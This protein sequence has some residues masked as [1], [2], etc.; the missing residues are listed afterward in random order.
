MPINY[1]DLICTSIGELRIEDMALKALNAPTS[2]V[3]LRLDYL[4][5]LEVDKISQ[6]VREAENN[7]KHVIV[8]LRDAGEGGRYV[9]SEDFKANLLEELMKSATPSYVDVEGSFPKSHMLRVK[10]EKL[11]VRTIISYH[12]Y[13]ETPDY[14]KLSSI[15]RENIAKKYDIVKVVTSAKRVEDNLTTLK[16]CYQFKGKTISFCMGRLGRISRLLAPFFGAPFTYAVGWDSEVLA[17][18]QLRV[19]EVVRVWE[20]LGLM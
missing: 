19:E 14:E 16:I 10:A 17:P 11:G 9:G 4:R 3:E 2:L 13:Y 15:V 1:K 20:I 6:L 5:A 18:G 8:T 7:G 12:N